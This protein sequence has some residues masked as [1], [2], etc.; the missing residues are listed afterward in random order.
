MAS[1]A[2]SMA[3]HLLPAGLLTTKWPR[4]RARRAL[5]SSPRGVDARAGGFALPFLCIGFALLPAMLLIL[6]IVPDDRLLVAKLFLG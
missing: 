6:W 4:L 5:D 2:A 1:F 3:A